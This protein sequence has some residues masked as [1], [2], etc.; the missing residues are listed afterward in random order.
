MSLDVCKFVVQSRPSKESH[1]INYTLELH[2]GYLL[3][4]KHSLKLKRL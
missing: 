3:S 1:E 4:R 2:K